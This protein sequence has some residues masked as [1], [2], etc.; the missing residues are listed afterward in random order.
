MRE[1]GIKDKE[2]SVR[3]K[4]G[5]KASISRNLKME[6]FVFYKLKKIAEKS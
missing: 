1:Q 4:W 3:L 6:H 5:R 2:S